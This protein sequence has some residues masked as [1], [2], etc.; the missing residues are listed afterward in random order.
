MDG[1]TAM[2]GGGGGVGE[3]LVGHAA[4]Y[5]GMGEPRLV[6]VQ[7]LVVMMAFLAV[8]ASE[9]YSS[10]RTATWRRKQQQQQQQLQGNDDEYALQCT[11]PRPAGSVSGAA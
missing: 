8:L 5:D 6:S 2:G 10:R 11:L 7:G 9:K 4:C 1:L 3:M